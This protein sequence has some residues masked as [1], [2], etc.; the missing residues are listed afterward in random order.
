MPNVFQL[1]VKGFDNNYSYLVPG[2]GKRSKE[3]VLIDP[4]GSKEVVEG[5]IAKHGLRVALVLLTHSHPDHKELVSHFA[6]KGIKVFEPKEARLGHV[7]QLEA[8]GLKIKAIHTPGHT[9][10]GVC[11]LIGKN[12]F[13]GD[14]LFVRGIGTTAY[15]GDDKELKES[16]NFLASFSKTEKGLVLWPGHN[17]GGAHAP[18]LEALS[19]SHVK[20]SDKALEAIKKRVAEYEK[21]SLS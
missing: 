16:L 14:T 6:S 20:P 17:Y 13:S 10:E 7:E 18:L 2:T 3:A 12:I 19:N 15:G 9:K 4:T 8:A 11:Y 5:A 1:S 21:G